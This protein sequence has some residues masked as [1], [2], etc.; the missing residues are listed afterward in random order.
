[1]ADTRIP[2]ELV[3]KT[4]AKKAWEAGWHNAFFE[5]FTGSDARSII[6]VKEEL[7]KG[8]GTSINIP[9]LLPLNEAG[10]L[11]DSTLEGNEEALEY[12]SFDVYIHQIRHAVRLTGRFEEKKTQIN[13]RKDAQ[14]SLA[15]WLGMYIDRSLFAVLTG[16]TPK[17]AETDPTKFPFPVTPPT[18]GRIITAGAGTTEAAITPGDT[19]STELIGQAKRLALADEDTAVRPIKVNG[20]DTYVMVIDQYQ[21]RDL[22]LDQKWIDAQ[23]YANVR[24]ENNP[25]FSGALGIYDGVV[26][27]E[28]N[29]VPRTQTGASNAMVGHALFLGAQAA[30]F[31]EGESPRWV[32]KKFDYDNKYGVSLSRMFGVQKSQF[33]YDGT[34]EMDFGVINVLTSS[35]D[36]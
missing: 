29:R 20:K 2:I 19:F 13:M 33:K 24:G 26:I 8:P 32:E 31:A 30:V 22:K 25:I 14:T 6:H 23:Q 4:W 12:R 34:N 3:L 27:H 11:D 35:M 18:A 21:A 9:L 28:S 5:K 17:W 15:E 36:D 7:A 10:V 1:M 16:V